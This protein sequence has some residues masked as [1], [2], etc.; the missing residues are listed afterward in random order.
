MNDFPSKFLKILEKFASEFVESA[1]GKTDEEIRKAILSSEASIY[2]IEQAK[3]EDAKLNGCKD[4][5]KELSA[6]YRESKSAETAKIKYCV[7]LLESRG[8]PINKR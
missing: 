8:S 4:L 1:N 3:D 2:D 6:P 7:Y 5:L